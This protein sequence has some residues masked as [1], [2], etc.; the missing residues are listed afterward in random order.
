MKHIQSKLKMSS[1]NIRHYEGILLQ[2]RLEG[3]QLKKSG[4]CFIWARTGTNSGF[5]NE[6]LPPSKFSLHHFR[7]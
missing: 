7:V 2:Y 5:L 1:P 3:L 6:N 4:G